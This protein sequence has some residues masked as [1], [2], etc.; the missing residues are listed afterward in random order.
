[1][2]SEKLSHAGPRRLAGLG[3]SLPRFLNHRSLINVAPGLVTLGLAAWFGVLSILSLSPP[4][5]LNNVPPTEFSSARARDYLKPL[6]E[7]PHPIGSLAHAEVRDHILGE[8]VKIGLQPQVQKTTA[9]NTFWGHSTRAATVENIVAK[10]EGTAST[11]AVLLVAHYD[12]APHSLGASDNGAAVV[13]LLETLRA[14]KA[15]ERLKNDVIFLATDGEEVGLLG[16]I[17]FI[18]QHPWAKDV[19]VALNFEAR[20]DH[21]PSIMF[22]TSDENG[23][24]IEEF[25]KTVP[26]PVA[27]S[28]T[29]DIYKFLPNDTDFTVFKRAGMDGLNF[30]YIEGSASYHSSL[31]N[32]AN[33]DARSLQ[34]H[35][36][37]ALTLTRHFGNSDLNRPLR[38]SD[39]V[40]FDVFGRTLIHYS[41][42]TALVLAIFVALITLGVIALGFRRKLLTLSGQ[43]LGFLAL[44][45]SMICAALSVMLAWWLFSTLDGSQTLFRQGDTWTNHLYL[46]GFALLA[47]AAAATVYGLFSKKIS[48]DNLATGALLWFLLLMI[49]SLIVLPG[50]SYL[51][52]WPLLSALIV[53]ILRFTLPPAKLSSV[54]L[55]LIATLG[56]VPGI[57]LMTPLIYQ[58]FVALGISLT[59][60]L[61]VPFTLMLGLLIVNFVLIA[62]ARRWLLPAV[63]AIAAVCFMITAL[64]QPDF[65]QR[66]PKQDEIFYALDADT[67]KAVWASGDAQADEWTSQFLSSDA[68]TA[69]LTDYFPWL[70]T[71]VFLQQQ[72]QVAPLPAPEIE[73]V[74]DQVQEQTRSIRM[75]IKSPREAATLFIHVDS[76]LSEKFVNGQLIATGQGGPSPEKSWILIYSAPPREGIDLLFKTRSSE[77]LIMKVVDR[78]FQLP[79]LTNL[80]IKARPSHIIPAPFTY[81]DSTF[82]GK[83]FS[84]PPPAA[85]ATTKVANP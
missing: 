56:A 75:R 65:N 42:T 17:A 26:R 62:S 35:G 27:N 7:K 66:V 50:G 12:A 69:V 30:A 23:W 45:L 14:L 72:A 4:D 40:Y 78:S 58:I 21:G 19:G 44:L 36:M 64:L 8:L 41:R 68:H 53:W 49:L 39:A 61:V 83:S 57:I 60:L 32:M 74:D 9:I 54:K 34:H 28:L 1:M 10:L 48:V 18:Q 20:G 59:S 22:Q 15:S 70:K 73:V 24:L 84:L 85:Q 31:D 55:C 51:L 81:T 63:T 67:G 77:P 13:T 2:I 25:A 3:A 79:E 47:V 5:I 11:R 16:A 82:I 29:A 6:V 38:K 46:I 33:L 52:L 76:E 71:D 80:T 43:A 37:Y